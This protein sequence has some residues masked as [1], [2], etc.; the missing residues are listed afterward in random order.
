M[1]ILGRR[2][3]NGVP[4]GIILPGGS[5]PSLV[6]SL[7]AGT[8]G[9]TTVPVT[10]GAAAGTAAISY[11]GRTS[12]HGTGN[13]TQNSGS[14]T[15]TGGT[16]IGLSPATAYD[17]RIVAT[18]AFGTSTTDLLT[19][20]STTAVTATNFTVSLSQ[21]SGSAGT[22]VIMTI[23]PV[24]SA[25]PSGEVVSPSASGLAGSFDNTSLTALGTTPLIFTFTPI[26]SPGT[27][28]TLTAAAA[29]MTNSSGA[30]AYSINAVVTSAVANRFDLVVTNSAV[31]VGSPVQV[32]VFP[33]ASFPSGT[34]VL[35]GTNGSFA[36]NPTITLT[37]GSTTPVT[38]TY[39]PASG[40]EHAISATNTSGLYNPY[41][42]PLTVFSSS[43]GTPQPLAVALTRSD[44]VTYQR[45]APSGNPSGFS[46]AWA[47][48]WGEV[49]LS[50][51]SLAGATSG[52]WVRLYDAMSTGASSSTGSGSALHSSPV[53]VY[54]AISGPRTARVLLPA[55]P[56]IYYADVATDAA[57]TNPVRIA[58]RF[59][60]G[61][62]IGHFSRSQ[63]SG[64]SRSYA[65]TNN[66]P[67][68]TNYKKTATWVGFDYR[69]QDYDSGWYV[70]D[71]VTPD[72]YQ[73]HYSEG[74]S[75]GAQEIGRLIESQLGVCVGIAGNSATGGGLDSMVNHDGSLAGGFPGTV[76]AATGS[77]FRYFWMATGGW[78]G[79]DSTN[80]PNETHAEVRTRII[81]AVSWI[82]QNFPACAV[83]GWCTSASGLFGSDGSRTVGYTRNQ[84]IL[85]NEVEPSNP[86]VVSKENY[87]WN[88]YNAFHATMSA[89]VDYVRPG[90]RKLMAAE[91]SVMG[92][93][94]SAARGP[95]LA[96]TGTYKAS[97]RVISIPYT[98]PSGASALQTIGLTYS[99]PNPVT[100]NGATTQEIAGLFAVYGPGGYQSNGTAIKIDSAT[101]NSAAKTIDLAL[102]G[103]TGVT[104][105]DGT[106]GAAPSGFS[107]QFA[108][109]FGVSNGALVPGS[110]R[111]AVITD[112]RV[113]TA[114]GI[115]YGWHMLPTLDIA[116]STV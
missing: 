81:G 58:Q 11:S 59:R 115:P 25:W 90:F 54:G 52:L 55:G 47:K 60:V 94:Q 106:T 42:A 35:S 37:R 28:G 65:Y 74:S 23:T 41:P 27:S 107:V 108:A 8:P 20:I 3:L 45:D 95:T 114:N 44:M 16:F 91:L 78:D 22:A 76:A 17:L 101:I 87:N 53:Q 104:Y 9:T 89:R 39:T 68:P 73:Y 93:F 4:M 32:T 100:I 62:V 80:Y 79:V 111:S 38:V 63:E 48:G 2:R 61:V 97:A 34:I 14:F 72:P 26:S 40:G 102:T 12:N 98:L 85:L 66:T 71:G 6:G 83:V 67:L 84:M 31:A 88:E 86:M 99:N 109:D 113:D 51:T 18:N 46:L 49:W 21:S 77:K 82:A 70:H 13:W 105:A 110:G 64:L 43:P 50:V 116:I 29:G 103:S 33:N 36:T 57:F 5:A 75:S 24:S 112:D 15:Q 19:G 7:S 10:F 30:Q 1:S 96:M 56:Y 69:Y 92:G